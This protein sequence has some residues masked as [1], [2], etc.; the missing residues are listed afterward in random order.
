M[1]V[2]EARAGDGVLELHAQLVDVH[3]D[4][5]VAGAQA[6]SPDLAEEVVAAD[7]AA[8]RS[9]ERDEEAE[10]ADGQRQRASA[11]G[12]QAV[13]G[14]DLEGAYLQDV[15]GLHVDA[16]HVHA[17]LPRVRAPAVTRW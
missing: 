10:L 2:D 13:A 1:R 6:P 15:R 11:R 14:L 3:V 17:M 5:T 8:A 9:G 4:R 12:H 16:V 7:D